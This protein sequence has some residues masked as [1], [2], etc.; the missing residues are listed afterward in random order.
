MNICISMFIVNNVIFSVFFVNKAEKSDL[1]N[2]V[3]VLGAILGFLL[4]PT[5]FLTGIKCDSHS[6][7][8]TL[9]TLYF[10]LIISLLIFGLHG[11]GTFL[12]VVRTFGFAGTVM[13][14][15]NIYMMNLIILSKS[16][17]RECRALMYGCCCGVG[18]FG[19]VLGLTIGE[20]IHNRINPQ[21]LY[22]LEILL[23]IAYMILYYSLGG[24]KQFVDR[25]NNE[26]Y[27]H[28]GIIAKGDRTA[29]II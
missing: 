16:V 23:C 24:T 12:Q 20:L 29:S 11:K 8:P 10:T 22:I 17:S 28:S 2:L 7:W 15:F 18:A 9:M 4:V 3:I 19:A 21:T 6:P 14:L 27:K 5:I 13:S 26:K 1:N 25:W